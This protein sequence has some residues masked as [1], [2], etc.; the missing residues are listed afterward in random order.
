MTRL[1][2][3]I[4]LVLALAPALPVF[5]QDLSSLLDKGA[6]LPDGVEAV[7]GEG[8]GGI[9]VARR[10]GWLI[11]TASGGIRARA[12]GFTIL[13]DRAVFWVRPDARERV[14]LGQLPVQAIYAEGS[15]F[16]AS[17]GR[18][19][20]RIVTLRDGRRLSGRV[21]KAGDRV[22][23]TDAAGTR[24]L[25]RSEIDAI[26]KAPSDTGLRIEADRLFL[27][28][29]GSRA[30]I[31]D[32]RARIV[33][34]A[35]PGA[36][37]AGEPVYLAAKR[38][39]LFGARELI[40]R[41]VTITSCDFGDPH[42]RLAV[43]T[44]RLYVRGGAPPAAVAAFGGPG[45]TMFD[46]SGA[47]FLLRDVLEDRIRL[48]RGVQAGPR[49]RAA[50]GTPAGAAA[51]TGDGSVSAPEA[52]GD[53]RG[54][55][56][57]TARPAAGAEAPADSGADAVN[58]GNPGAPPAGTGSDRLAEVRDSGRWIA[59]DDVRVYAGDV[60]I[61]YLPKLVWK[62][63][64]DVF[65]T[66]SF[67]NSN[68]FGTFFDLEWNLPVTAAG[69]VTLEDGSSVRDGLSSTVRA[70]GLVSSRRGTSERLGLRWKY[71]H[72]GRRVS[73]GR[74]LAT[75][76]QDSGRDRNGDMRERGNRGWVYG[77]VMNDLLER[78]R[79]D[80]EVSSISDR[81][82]LL[83]F[84]ER[85]A[86]T[87]KQQETYLYLHHRED[88]LYAAA[89]SRWRINDFQTYTE[90]LPELTLDLFS[91]P[92]FDNA[93]IPGQATLNGAVTGAWLRQRFDN[94]LNRPTDELLRLD[95]FVEV[96]EKTWLGPVV[97][98]GFVRQRFTAYEKGAAG[99]DER[100]RL[101][102]EAGVQAS[103]T[104]SRR[105]GSRLVHVVVPRI[106]YFNRFANNVDPNELIQIDEVDAL[107]ETEF[108]F[109]RARTRL[110]VMNPDKV[111]YYDLVDLALEARYFPK[112][113]KDNGGNNWST[114]RADLRLFLPPFASARFRGEWD[115]NAGRN[116]T[117]EAFFTVRPR[118]DLELGASYRNLEGIAEAVGW[119]ALW[120]LNAKWGLRLE[121][122]YDFRTRRFITHRVTV[123]RWFHRFSLDVILN[124]DPGEGDIGVSFQLAPDLF[125]GSRDPFRDSRLSG[126]GY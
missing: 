72:E 38:L 59:L 115:V 8:R 69:K 9:E 35:R 24:R 43:D 105:Y 99:R 52:G 13:A 80:A 103:T 32:T 114:A 28:V 124:V 95:S 21:T 83:E 71:Y 54:S 78:T 66:V 100:A 116:V 125:N 93:L 51:K 26:R 58:A 30:L 14:E 47:E 92:L 73:N 101:A 107:R 39:S 7:G 18:K 111:S 113:P 84:E 22:F 31:F 16:A 25:K 4:A 108:L 91:Q 81:D 55:D 120:R 86:K 97:A 37:V 112:G 122:Q 15:V 49:A 89:L 102:S 123:R 119:S 104:L 126:I 5:G 6:A 1:G 36:G 61:L 27:D 63:T 45:A 2:R 17:G 87:E 79:L 23:V 40:G 34:P 12:G 110:S 53:T 11:V 65:P 77:A 60:P 48:A 57:T 42:F 50:S 68:S 46:R 29:A 76:L 106:G 75:A 62:S 3:L 33:P 82:Y 10:R 19:D 109:L 64:W 121:E 70:G 88:R 74:F 41:D 44:L 20:T 94:R 117:S 56:A 96:D 118:S 98:R 85:V 90:R 67:G